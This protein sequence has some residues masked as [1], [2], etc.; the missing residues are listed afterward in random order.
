[1]LDRYGI[2]LEAA[3]VRDALAESGLTLADVDGV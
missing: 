3:M 2:E 1:M